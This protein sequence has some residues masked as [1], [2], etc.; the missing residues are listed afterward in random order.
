MKETTGTGGARRR[1]RRCEREGKHQLREA[2]G[3]ASEDA[4]GSK[5]S[6]NEVSYGLGRR[7][8]GTSG[9]RRRSRRCEREGK[10]QLREAADGASG[11]A[12]SSKSSFNK[13]DEGAPQVPGGEAVDASAKASISCVKQQ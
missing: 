4:A 5:S 3:G 8:W 13:G 2:A 6:F 1:S 12:A 11:D 10:H 7:R 9:A